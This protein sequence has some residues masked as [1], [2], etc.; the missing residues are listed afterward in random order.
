M[1]RRKRELKLAE[2]RQARSD[3]L[4]ENYLSERT[5]IPPE[6]L[7]PPGRD[8]SFNFDN[9]T[10]SKD[11]AGTSN[12][13]LDSVE[14][15][16]SGSTHSSD[17]WRQFI[18][19]TF[20]RKPSTAASGSTVLG[21]PSPSFSSVWTSDTVRPNLS[22]SDLPPLCHPQP[23]KR[24]GYKSWLRSLKRDKGKEKQHQSDQLTTEISDLNDSDIQYQHGR[25][26]SNQDGSDM[27][28]NLDENFFEGSE[29]G[30]S[31]SKIE[32]PK[33]TGKFGRFRFLMAKQS[34]KVP[35]DKGK[36]RAVELDYESDDGSDDAHYPWDES[37]FEEE[38]PA[39]VDLDPEDDIGPDLG[40]T[41]PRQH[42]RVVHQSFAPRSLAPTRPL[43]PSIDHVLE[44]QKQKEQ[45]VRSLLVDRQ[46]R[47]LLEEAELRR[48][49]LWVYGAR[50]H[51]IEYIEY[52]ED[53]SEDNSDAEDSNSGSQQ[54]QQ[55]TGQVTSAAS[56][57]YDPLSDY[58]LFE[59]GVNANA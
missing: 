1:A 10:N 47:Q 13:G 9:H 15:D 14:Q 22:S 35:Q 20:R 33:S 27:G 55:H 34:A 17:T 52:L 59:N 30:N 4:R 24:A 41:S 18:K 56:D 37:R 6:H 11:G 19:T 54:Q 38:S 46:E 3:K 8:D 42:T 53:E 49:R 2:K 25:Y 58:L 43:L 50:T 29:E 48:Q 16:Q 44:S 12:Q 21:L 28:T 36:G 32:D 23:K 5:S 7:S 39:R 40:A 26:S 45:H 31:Q 57:E 51:I